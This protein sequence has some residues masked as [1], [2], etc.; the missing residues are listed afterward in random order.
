MEEEEPSADGVMKSTTEDVA[1]EEKSTYEDMVVRK[2]TH[3]LK[4]EKWKINAKLRV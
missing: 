3:L 1:V 4:L 2:N